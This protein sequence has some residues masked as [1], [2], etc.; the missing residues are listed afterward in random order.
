MQH[1]NPGTRVA[2][3]GLASRLI[4]LQS[5]TSSPQT[6]KDMMK[7]FIVAQVNAIAQDRPEPEAEGA[8]VGGT[9]GRSEARIGTEGS[10]PAPHFWESVPERRGAQSPAAQPHQEALRNLGLCRM[11]HNPSY[12]DSR[13][14]PHGAP[15]PL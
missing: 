6:L 4:L 11:R 14:M 10:L 2:I 1:A 8:G 12:A 9:G 13:I 5:F 7:K 3:F 15:V